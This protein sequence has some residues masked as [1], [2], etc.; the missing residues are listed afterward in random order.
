ME[1][2]LWYMR[3]GFNVV[4]VAVC[5][6]VGV[7]TATLVAETET[8]PSSEKQS[9]GGPVHITS[10]KVQSDQNESWVE[11]V[12]NVKATQD[13]SVITAERIKIFYKKSGGAT[14]GVGS[15]AIEKMVAEGSVKIVFDSDSKTATA[16]KA[17][18]TVNDRILVLSGGNPTV[19]S[20]KDVIRGKKITLFQA[21]DR[22][23]VE[24]DEA[25]QVE[26]TFHSQGEAGLIK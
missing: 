15:A 12:G 26:A 19:S 21:E 2:V 22:T 23:V 9:R 1:Q 10:D 3:R 24:G 4:A 11:F 25:N 5:L 6:M 20:G 8:K 13:D 17:V 18:Y 16:Q 7:M 14:Q